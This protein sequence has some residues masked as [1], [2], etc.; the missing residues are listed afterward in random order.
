MRHRCAASLSHDGA[1][2]KDPHMSWLSERYY[3]LRAGVSSTTTCGGLVN[4]LEDDKDPPKDGGLSP[5]P[6]IQLRS[7]LTILI[8]PE[9]A[10]WVKPPQ[11]VSP[12]RRHARSSKGSTTS[13]S[14]SH[15][16]WRDNRCQHASNPR[17]LPIYR[18]PSSYPGG[19]RHRDR[20]MA[21]QTGRPRD[22]AAN[23]ERKPLYHSRLHAQESAK[24]RTEMSGSHY[25]RP[26]RRR[27][28]TVVHGHIRRNPCPRIGAAGVLVFV[29]TMA[30]LGGLAHGHT[31]RSGT[32]VR[33]DVGV[34]QQQSASPAKVP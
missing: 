34:V 16:I 9:S 1:G 5:T 31:N 15:G 19:A 28:G 11:G 20:R 23:S 22:R 13:E 3:N 18:D 30:I 10:A 26:Y 32:I 27:D 2:F 8:L 24:G 6:Q 14:L 29:L 4:L 21:P 25:V 7:L 33:T 12:R 17:P